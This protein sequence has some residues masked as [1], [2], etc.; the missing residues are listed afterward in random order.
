MKITRR[1]LLRLLLLVTLLIVYV[2]LYP[3]RF[4]WQ[5][6]PFEPI[7]SAPDMVANLLLFMP[8][9]A[10][11]RLLAAT[12]PDAV[13]SDAVPD[14]PTRRER[15]V[16][17]LALLAGALLAAVLQWLQI[18]VPGRQPALMDIGMNWIGLGLGAAL[19]PVRWSGR[20]Q[21]AGQF[22]LGSRAGW[23]LLVWLL[24][25]W[26]PLL[27]ERPARAL[28]RLEA[29]G[30]W[31]FSRLP[32][33]WVAC[34]VAT[35]SWLLVL[36]LLPASWRFGKRAGFVLLVL[37]PQP[38][39]LGGSL[40]PHELLAPL[41]AGF[42]ATVA[43]G[44]RMESRRW[45]LLFALLAA[46][47]LLRGWWPWQ[48]LSVPRPFHLWPLEALMRSP[49]V[50]ALPILAEKLFCYGALLETAQR[51]GWPSRPVLVWLTLA[52]LM[53]ELG[54][55]W[56]PGHRPESTDVLLLWLMAGLLA[57]ATMPMGRSINPSGPVPLPG[58]GRQ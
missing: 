26:S 55:C 14:R 57:M 53:I 13:D 45:S 41:L 2:S 27:P 5:A 54:Q 32:L 7:W 34:A 37:L 35:V 40:R 36:A 15:N 24:A 42:V 6:I 9:G 17:A 43:I 39:L 30:L 20:W 38:W 10:L 56:L 58:A 50:L 11:A 29:F 33:D 8:F 49:I 51:A 19:T 18:F 48:W 44:C 21:A 12:T 4:R 47:L 16:L 31:P 23:L 1:M 22:W 52:V 28:A 3:F 46:A 25:Q